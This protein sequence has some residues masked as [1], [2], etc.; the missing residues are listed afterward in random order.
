[1][2]NKAF[3]PVVE[4][5]LTH[6]PIVRIRGLSEDEH[7]LDLSI[8]QDLARFAVFTLVMAKT[9]LAVPLSRTVVQ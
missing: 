8:E 5:N 1:M 4:V 9:R 3:L 2:S 7:Q 6:H